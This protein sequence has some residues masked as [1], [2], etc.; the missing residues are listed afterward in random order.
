MNWNSNRK[1]FDKA[2]EKYGE[3]AEKLQIKVTEPET[4]EVW[5]GVDAPITTE[6]W[7]A[8]TGI[9]IQGYGQLVQAGL[10]PPNLFS[11]VETPLDIVIPEPPEAE[12]LAAQL[13]NKA[14]YLYRAERYR[15]ITSRKTTIGTKYQLSTKTVCRCHATSDTRKTHQSRVRMNC[16]DQTLPPENTESS[17][18]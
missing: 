16:G 1:E 17:T 2:I 8:L 13:R 3:Y 11:T 12:G 4:F 10:L 18:R 9:I 6:Q 7:S 5:F 14:S 15:Q